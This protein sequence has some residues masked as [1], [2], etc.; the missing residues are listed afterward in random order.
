MTGILYLFADTNLFIQCRA[1]VE[2]DWSAWASF[3]EVHVIVS[4]PVQREI[5]YRKNKEA[6]ASAIDRGRPIRCSA[7]SSRATRTTG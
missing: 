1:L 3:D 7:R 6:T 5:D 4:R 2:L